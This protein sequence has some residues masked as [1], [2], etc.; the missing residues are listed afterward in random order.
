[1]KKT[2]GVAS[3]VILAC[4]ILWGS[5]WA[6]P[7]HPTTLERLVNMERID[8]WVRMI[9]D[10]ASRGMGAVPEGA[11][12]ITPERPSAELRVLVLLVAFPD[13]PM[14]SRYPVE[15][16]GK[17]FFKVKDGKGGSVAAFF[18]LNSGGA[19]SVVGKTAG[20]FDLP[21]PKGEYVAGRAGLGEYPRNAQRLVEDAVRA[22]RGV[23]F[24]D[25][26]GDGDGVVDVLVVVHTGRGVETT[27]EPNDLWSHAGILEEPVEVGTVR[28]ERYILAP[29]EVRVGLYCHELARLLGA[30]ILYDPEYGWT[31]LGAWSVM[32]SGVWG[33]MPALL[34][35]WSRVRLGFAQP[36]DVRGEL[37]HV[38]LGCGE[39]TP[40]VFR[41]YPGGEPGPEY[42][43]VECRKQHQR[44]DVNLPGEGVLIYHVD[45]RVPDNRYPCCGPGALHARVT[46]EQADGRCELETG[47]G[48]DASDLWAQ[49]GRKRIAPVDFGDNSRVNSYDYAGERTGVA[50]RN[51][52]IEKGKI[53][54][55]LLVNAPPDSG[56][57]PSLTAEV[58]EGEAGRWVVTI[59]LRTS[60][61]AVVDV[62]VRHSAGEVVWEKRAACDGSAERL[63]RWDPSESDLDAQGLFF[64]EARSEGWWEVERVVLP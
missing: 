12:V 55:D 47:K 38:D 27:G 10:G 22:A 35:A 44:F 50:V 30:P 17:T 60:Q 15:A 25:F 64:V 37:R 46:L 53:Y 26:D 51:L 56:A 42:F 11:P 54:G 8:A 59:R 24:E 32:G 49:F 40:P 23:H 41:L 62:R 31:G 48:A 29:A 6:V 1:M 33:T 4:T 36:I 57:E 21:N 45:E 28:V 34:D 18:D 3:T 16:F 61:P 58:E 5:A 19:L 20:L 63:L 2:P 9:E 52:A 39:P 13:Y 14:R 7:F 43:L